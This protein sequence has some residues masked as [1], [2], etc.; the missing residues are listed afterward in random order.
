M[1]RLMGVVI[2]HVFLGVISAMNARASEQGETDVMR[3]NRNQTY[4]NMCHCTPSPARAHQNRAFIGTHSRVRSDS[5]Q[6]KAGEAPDTESLDESRSRI[7]LQGIP[8][9]A[10]V[11]TGSLHGVSVSATVTRWQHHAR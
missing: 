10:A 11:Y 7:K 3:T 9:G 4:V 2:V 6:V 1:P 5:Q 8:S